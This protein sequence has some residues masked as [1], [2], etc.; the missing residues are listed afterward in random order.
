MEGWRLVCDFFMACSVKKS[1]GVRMQG[2]SARTFSTR[3]YGKLWEHVV[4]IALKKYGHNDVTILNSSWHL[5]HPKY[6]LI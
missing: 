4:K 1:D 2:V 6:V 5:H 3:L